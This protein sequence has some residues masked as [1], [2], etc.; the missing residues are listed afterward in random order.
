MVVGGLAFAGA[1]CSTSDGSAPSTDAGSAERDA[2]GSD[3]GGEAEDGSAVTSRLEAP[4]PLTV[5]E[6]SDA[7]LVPIAQGIDHFDAA[8]L[9]PGAHLDAKTGTVTFHPDFTQSGSYD[10]ALTGRALPPHAAFEKTVHLALTVRPSITPIAPVI[11][12][13]TEGSGFTRLTVRQV[14]DAFLDSPGY[15]GRTFD[16]IVVVPKL[17]AGTR[18]PVI[19]SLHG[20]GGAPDPNAGSTTTFRIE[21]HDPYET[22]WWGY[23]DALPG[24]PPAGHAPPYT[25]RRVLHLVDWLLRAYPAADPD[26]VFASG[27]SMGGAGALTMGLLHARHFAGVDATIAQAIPRN[28]RPSRIA[29]LTAL[30]GSPA[31]NL[32][33][34]WDVGD[35]TRV[36]RDVPEAREQLVFTKHGKDDPTIHFGAVVTRSAL[37]GKTFYESL[38]EERIGHLSIWDEGA[39]GPADPVLGDHW[40]DA[41]WSRVTDGKSRLGRRTAFPAFSRSSA[42]G[43]PGDGS[44][45]GKVPFEIETGYSANVDVPGDTGWSGDIAGA[46]NR[47]LRWDAT[48]IT[49]ERD[50]FAMPLFVV[51]SPGTAPPRDGYPT[52][53]DL[54]AGTPPITVDVTIRRAQRFRPHAG[55]AVHWAFGGLAGD[56]AA[57]PDGSVTVPA[58]PLTTTATVLSLAARR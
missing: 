46:L 48:A 24:A 45:N 22:Y 14:T 40:W 55:E 42:N 33:G 20:F 38:E 47:F 17:A 43:N 6:E 15:A 27:A 12:A 3:G 7:A 35:V 23:S 18:A 54:Y 30:W 36:L 16:A 19:V 5:D 53:G 58:L 10:I 1:A 21:P 39:H 34:M 56:V 8:D 25:M 41:S 9:P 44:G 52:K 29:Q 37:T 51:T 2:V 28:H 11:V 31:A 57:S 49:D 32:D 4:P 13:Q 50:S 26:R